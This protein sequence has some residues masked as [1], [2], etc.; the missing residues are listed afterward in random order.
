MKTIT[1]MSRLKSQIQT[2]D[3]ILENSFT[4]KVLN[5][6]SSRFN[7]FLTLQN[8]PATTKGVK[9][10]AIYIYQERV[11]N[12]HGNSEN[13][14]SFAIVFTYKDQTVGDKIQVTLKEGDTIISSDKF[15]LSTFKEHL[16]TFISHLV[17]MQASGRFC[18]NKVKTFVVNSFI[19]PSFEKVDIQE[20]KSIV[21]TKLN[22]LAQ[23]ILKER[24][25]QK[26][27]E[28][29]IEHSEK[30]VKCKI[31]NSPEHQNIVTLDARIDELQKQIDN[32]RR[33]RNRY[34]QN[35]TIIS[36]KLK[37]IEK[38]EEK[39]SDLISSKAAEK[40]LLEQAEKL[41]LISNLDK[42]TV[43]QL[44]KCKPQE[45]QENAV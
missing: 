17:K 18:S 15:D 4:K 6:A 25:K 26:E 24:S 2:L 44:L 42:G 43:N 28:K 45:K 39:N 30:K 1:P 12:A 14:F 13:T 22:E 19:N 36:N 7:Y 32:L 35:C 10:D 40:R 33:E 37:S 41:C 31:Q 11:K 5:A 9:S 29:D 21:L 23:L 34:I 27:L 16:K 8:K 38:I 3:L 20:E